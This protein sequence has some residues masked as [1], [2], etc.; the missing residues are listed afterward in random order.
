MFWPS[1]ILQLRSPS[2]PQVKL[3]S[4]NTMNIH[5]KTNNTS[6]Q[7]T[8]FQPLDLCDEGSIYR[9]LQ[10]G[11]SSFGILI[12]VFSLIVPAS[13]WRMV[14][15]YS[16]LVE[17]REASVRGEAS[18]RF[19]ELPP[20]NLSLPFVH[21]RPSHPTEEQFS[22]HR[23]LYTGKVICITPSAWSF[24]YGPVLTIYEQFSVENFWEMM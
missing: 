3:R 5:Q 10:R 8:R 17:N 7:D 11:E 13:T 24:Q 20:R 22:V 12:S 9:W 14:I 15:S 19:H 16:S 18:R 23:T 21:S 4:P 6:L 2:S 1:I